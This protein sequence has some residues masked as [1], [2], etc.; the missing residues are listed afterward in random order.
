[1]DGKMLDAVNVGLKYNLY[2]KY[3]NISFNEL[4]GI[5]EYVKIP[6]SLEWLDI[7]GNRIGDYG[8]ISMILQMK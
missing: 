4:Q 3:L 7:E 8:I 2:L 6:V 1:M 5:K